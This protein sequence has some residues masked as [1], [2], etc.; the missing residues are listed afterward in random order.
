MENSARREL[1]LRAA[2]RAE[3]VRVKCGIALTATVDPLLVAEKQDCEV[4]FMALP[5]LEGVYSP[6]PRPVIVLGSQRPTGRRAFTCA[7]ELGHHEFKHGA[8]VEELNANRFQG[9]K[10]PDEFLADMFAAFL[11]MSQAS[12]RRALKDREFKPNSIEPVQIFRLACNFGVGYGTLI[13]H[14]TWTLRLLNP[15]HRKNL[16][17]LQPKEMKAQFGGSPQSEVVLVD[18]FWRDRAVDLEVGDILVLQQGVIVE[19]SPRLNRQGTIDGQQTFMAV[20]RGYIRAFHEEIGWAV[21]IRVASKHYEGLAR[22]RFLDD[23]EEASN[24]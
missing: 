12:V 20:A 14:M 6:A 7:H 13:D 24:D 22:Y 11:L 5:S 16:L 19:D 4:R 15:Q 17:K 8:R 21:N 2:L 18:R 9:T 10:D 1:V 23:P 3:H